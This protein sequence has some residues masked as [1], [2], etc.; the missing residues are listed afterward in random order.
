V[1][2]APGG[3]SVSRRDRTDIKTVRLIEI[4]CRRRTATEIIGCGS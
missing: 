4:G 1:M 2:R 3:G